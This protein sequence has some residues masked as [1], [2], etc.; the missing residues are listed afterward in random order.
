MKDTIFKQHYL[1]LLRPSFLRF[2]MKLE[3]GIHPLMHILALSNL[4]DWHFYSPVKKGGL[5]RFAQMIKLFLCSKSILILIFLPNN[6][7]Y[8]ICLSY[9]IFG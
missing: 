9:L 4:T 5:L 7:F 3:E 2:E 1:Q 8:C 6:N